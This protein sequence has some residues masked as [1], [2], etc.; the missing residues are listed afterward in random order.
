MRFRNVWIHVLMEP[1]MI[2]IAIGSNLPHPVLGTPV[3]VCLTALE[4][5]SKRGCEVTGC[6]RWYRSSP[7]EATGQPDYVN[8]MIS[9][10]SSL[11]PPALLRELHKI[12][13]GFGRRRTVPNAARIL[14]L[15]II[16]Y[17]EV[18]SKGD[19]PPILPHPRM[20]KRAFVLLPLLD[21]APDWVHPESGMAGSELLE[22]LS[23]DQVCQPITI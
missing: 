2:L 6:S 12:E 10:Q 13:A 9:V 18:I 22:V 21:I 23:N 11:S 4:T 15:D 17:H 7:I 3:E 16:A 19:P 8:G 20:S 5:I 14:D 1:V